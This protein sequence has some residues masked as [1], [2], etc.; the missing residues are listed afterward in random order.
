[1]RL[2]S[3]SEQKRVMDTVAQL[4]PPACCTVGF[5]K[6]KSLHDL[7]QFISGAVWMKTCCFPFHCR[8]ELGALGVVESVEADVISDHAL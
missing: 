4:V 6:G 3:C 2:A 7:C 8:A 5:G 1:M